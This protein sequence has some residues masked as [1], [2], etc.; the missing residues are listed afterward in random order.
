MFGELDE[1]I[2]SNE[3]KFRVRYPVDDDVWKDV[4]VDGQTVIPAGTPMVLRISRLSGSNVGGQG[5]SLQIMAVSV[6]PSMAPRFRS[7][8]AMTRR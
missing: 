1:R 3:N 7:L 8:T 5:G 4:I 2:T 6:K